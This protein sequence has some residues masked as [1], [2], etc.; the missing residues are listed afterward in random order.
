MA[1]SR[2]ALLAFAALSLGATAPPQ[3][4]PGTYTNEEDRYFTA[5]RGA[6]AVPD[7]MGVEVNEA[8][9]WRSVDAF[10]K[11]LGEWHKQALPVETRD[12][13]ITVQAANGVTTEL[14]RARFFKC[15]I[16]SRRYAAKPDGS[17]DYINTFNLKL[18]DQ[19]GRV[20]VSPEGA[21]SVLIRLR[22]VIWPPPS[23]NNPSLV[24]YIH[25]PDQPDHAVSYSWADPK[26]DR[27]GINLRWVQ[28]NCI[29][30]VA[31]P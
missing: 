2:L 3:L 7:W 28:A 30:E 17:D 22:Y 18:H 20:Q 10:G 5:D 19:G 16:F 25:R 26:A 13:R 23:T 1:M 31:N 4:A 12:G 27:I 29:R 14:R 15:W 24:L 8:N 6:A 21:P 11:P 9:E